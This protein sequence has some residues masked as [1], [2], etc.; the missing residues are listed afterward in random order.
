MLDTSNLAEKIDTTFT[1]TQVSEL[2]EMLSILHQ[3]GKGKQPNYVN[4]GELHDMLIMYHYYLHL[5]TLCHSTYKKVEALM[6]CCIYR[7]YYNPLNSVKFY[8]GRLIST[9]IFTESS[10]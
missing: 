6:A 2:T 5:F 1:H 8:P 7:H 9:N 10:S 4:L 3:N